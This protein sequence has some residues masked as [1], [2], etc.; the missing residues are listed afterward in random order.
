MEMPKQRPLMAVVNRLHCGQKVNG[1]SGCVHI[2]I[3]D[4]EITG[5]VVRRDYLD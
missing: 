4:L 1:F 5:T 2:P 3:G